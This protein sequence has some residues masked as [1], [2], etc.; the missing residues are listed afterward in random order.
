MAG[1][2]IWREPFPLT[3]KWQLFGNVGYRRTVGSGGSEV[4][5]GAS[6]KYQSGTNADL[7]EIAALYLNPYAIVDLRAGV[8]VNGSWTVQAYVTN[9]ADQK[10]GTFTSTVS[11]D[12][13]VRLHRDASNLQSGT[14]RN[15][16]HL[17]PYAISA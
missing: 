13:N 1:A 5:A 7:G 8:T 14:R 17:N 6:I 4:F 12:V 15:R 3:P 11:P 10:Y 9:V 16:S 2:A